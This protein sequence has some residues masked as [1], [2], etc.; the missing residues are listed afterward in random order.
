[1]N[2][3]QQIDV[4]CERTDF[5]LWAE[6]L[7]AI[8]N[9]SFLAGAVFLFLQS[10]KP[11]FREQFQLRIYSLLILAIFVGSS[12]FHTLATQWAALVDV[13]LILVFA[14]Y[15]LFQVLVRRFFLSEY[16][17]GFVVFVFSVVSF[18]V[19]TRFPIPQLYGGDAY[20]SYLGSI[21]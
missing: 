11:Q 16:L 19:P 3:A 14:A 21:S 18:V 5:S 4:Y 1:M 12:L 6:P 13:L 8:S 7:N 2:W 10:R 17:S 15:F 20:F 9:L